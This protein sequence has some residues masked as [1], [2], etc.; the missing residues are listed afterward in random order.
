MTKVG[1]PFGANQGGY[2]NDFL[3]CNLV[4]H[5]LNGMMIHVN[6]QNVE[7]YQFYYASNGDDQS[8]VKSQIHGDQS[9]TTK[10]EFMFDKN[11]KIYKVRGQLIGE[12]ILLPNGTKIKTVRI[13]GLEFFSEGGQM[14]PSYDGPLGEPFTDELDGYTLGYVTGRASQHIHQLQFVWYRTVDAC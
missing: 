8:S 14:S 12:D 10:K 2:F 6:D 11:D 7:S 4:C 9:F 3:E 5:Y 1:Q 13:T